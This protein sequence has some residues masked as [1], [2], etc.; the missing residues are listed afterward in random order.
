MTLQNVYAAS[1][2][3]YIRFF[4]PGRIWTALPTTSPGMR[5]STARFGARVTL[6]FSYL[7]S[8]TYDLFLVGPRTLPGDNPFLLMTNLAVRATTNLNPPFPMRTSKAADVNFS[9]VHSSARGDLNTL[10]P[11][12]RALRATYHPSQLSVRLEFRR[13]RS[14]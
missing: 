9:Y 7:S 8:H 2:R 12:I 14:M 10:R 3:G 5:K 4:P 13:S 1:T 6:R 11:G